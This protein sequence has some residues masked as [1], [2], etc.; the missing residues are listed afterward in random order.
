MKCSNCGER[1]GVITLTQIEEGEV[2]TSNLCA[3]CAKAK[4]IETGLELAGTPLGG[5][6]AA[7]GE[8]FDREPS[9]AESGALD[10]RCGSCGATLQDFRETGRVGCPECWRTFAGPLRELLRRLHG[11]THHT[12]MRYE[13]AGSAPDTAPAPASPAN[14]LRLREELRHAIEAEQFERAAELRDQLREHE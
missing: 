2:K 11:S 8:S 5:F 3:E 7:L 1:E 14:V 4:G 6:L 10:A 12:G 13:G 9:V